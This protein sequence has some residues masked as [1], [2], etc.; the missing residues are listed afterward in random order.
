MA[1]N[2]SLISCD[3]L[4]YPDIINLCWDATH[5]QEGKIVY[6]D[7]VFQGQ[8]TDPTKTY[9]LTFLGIDVVLCNGWLPKMQLATQQLCVPAYGVFKFKNCET[10]L[11]K[12]LGFPVLDPTKAVIREDGDCNCWEFV[13]EDSNAAQLITNYTEYDD[14]TECLETRA[15]EVCT[16]GERTLSYAVSVKLPKQPPIDRGFEECCFSQLVLADIADGAEYKNDF[17]G[18]YFKRQTSLD[19]VNFI[20]TNLDTTTDYAL[21]DATYGTFQDFGGPQ[22]DLSFYIVDW[23]KVLTLLGKGAYRIKKE[24][25]VSGVPID[26]L[27]NTLTLKPFSIDIAD[28]TARLDSTM[29]GLLVS[30]NVDFKNSG[31]KTSLRFKGF[32]GNNN[33]SYE[34]DNLFK[35][36]YDTI[37][38][39]MSKNN[40]YRL[41][42]SNMFECIAN[43]LFNFMIFG[44]VVKISDYNKNNHS[45][46]YELTPVKFTNSEGNQ[47]LPTTRGVTFN[48]TFT[49]QIQN[50]RKTNC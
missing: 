50:N 26:L 25:V 39:T 23:R 35:N 45:Y 29:D 13:S 42:G 36:D 27:G 7:Q 41:Y 12:T 31:Y 9:T 16:T 33:P 2:Y 32:F 10:G 30:E 47:Y 40:E 38:I 46:L 24:L 18:A 44:N 20:L 43:E 48:L 14:C 15:A 34:Q 3:N 17:T 1:Y 6:V 37:Q 8:P 5:A 21:V 11:F 49:D 19:T 22:D 28:K 4:L